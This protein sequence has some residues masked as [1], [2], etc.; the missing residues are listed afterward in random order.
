MINYVIYSAGGGRRFGQ[1][2]RRDSRWIREQTSQTK[3]PPYYLLL[4]ISNTGTIWNKYLF[5]INEVRDNLRNEQT[6][7]F[8]ND[9]DGF[10]L[11]ICASI[12]SSFRTMHPKNTYRY[13]IGY[14]NCNLQ[15]L[16]IRQWIG[17]ILGFST[18]LKSKCTFKN[19]NYDYYLPVLSTDILYFWSHSTKNS[20]GRTLTKILC[21]QRSNLEEDATSET[22]CATDIFNYIEMI[23]MCVN[24]ILTCRNA[25]S[26]MDCIYR[27]SLI[28]VH[29][30][31]FPHC[32]QVAQLRERV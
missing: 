10:I 25:C 16:I 15:L 9:N 5:I 13:C 8:L 1:W 6:R 11:H 32:Q 21:E 26:W 2:N 28:A 17:V 3:F 4:L 14:D 30:M 20:R 18:I 22:V 19:V 23:T 12:P 7:Q 24:G 29:S 27:N 31:Q